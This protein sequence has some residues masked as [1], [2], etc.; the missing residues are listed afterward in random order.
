MKVNRKI[1]QNKQRPR[2]WLEGKILLAAGYAPGDHYDLEYNSN[3]FSLI[4]DRQGAR[5]VSGKGEKPI[6]DILGGAIEKAD[7]QH[8]D[9]VTVEVVRDLIVVSL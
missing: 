7:F 6:V 1:G 5:K 3:G 8:G 2:L 4:P 9:V